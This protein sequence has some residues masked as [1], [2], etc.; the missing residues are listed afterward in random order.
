MT[1]KRPAQGAP[2]SGSQPRRAA[3][4]LDIVDHVLDKGIVIDYRARVSI[5]GID[6]LMTVDARYVV[7]SCR[8]QLEYG[9]ALRSQL[10]HPGIVRP[11]NAR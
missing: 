3:T 7:T 6:T 11:W 9:N 8:T 10:L 2:Q 5:G 4:A 1:R